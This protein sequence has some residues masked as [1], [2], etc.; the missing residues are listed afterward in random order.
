VRLNHSIYLPGDLGTMDGIM[1]NMMDSL[2]EDGD[3]T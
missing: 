3:L 1:G 2:G